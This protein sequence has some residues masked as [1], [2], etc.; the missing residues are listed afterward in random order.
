M[1]TEINQQKKALILIGSISSLIIL[2]V[3]GFYVY[4]TWTSNTDIDQTNIVKDD[5]YSIRNNATDYQKELYA[6]LKEAIET[7]PRNDLDVSALVAQNFVADFY[8]WTNKFRMNDVGGIQFIIES[9][10]VNVYQ[11]AQ[12]NL[13]QDLYYYLNNGGLSGTLEVSD[14]SVVSKEAIDFFI[15]DD[16]GAEEIYDEVT[17]R[18]RDG[19]YHDAIEVVLNWSYVSTNS[20]DA[21]VYDQS[22]TVILMMNEKNLPMVVEVTHE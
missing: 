22:A 7:S 21:S 18:Y 6:A 3:G 13:Y 12:V 4:K 5:Y 9:M 10:Q 16:E 2:L 14:I 15:F 17:G 20:F 8:T 19:D 11:S 1:R